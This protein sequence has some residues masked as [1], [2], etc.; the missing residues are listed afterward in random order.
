M[1]TIP[2]S[3][4]ATYTERNPF[5][6]TERTS[7]THSPAL[8]TTADNGDTDAS[9]TAAAEGE[10]PAFV[11]SRWPVA[12][13]TAAPIGSVIETASDTNWIPTMRINPTRSCSCSTARRVIR[14]YEISA[15]R[16][17]SLR[18]SGRI[19]AAQIDR[20]RQRVAE[21]SGNRTAIATASESVTLIATRRHD[22]T[23]TAS[24]RR[25]RRAAGHRVQLVAARSPAGHGRHE[26]PRAVDE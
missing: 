11:I 17:A 1:A 13:P 3:A 25:R 23:A 24:T 26:L 19:K 9:E 20:S 8:S 14:E 6:G 7:D 10:T 18:P 16:A 21:P 2:T 5:T 12:G 15:A 22:L 4:A